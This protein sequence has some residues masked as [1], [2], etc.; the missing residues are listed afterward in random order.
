L[1]GGDW[2]KF[3]DVILAVAAFSVIY[4][5]VVAVLLMVLI[6]PMGSYLAM[7]TAGIV[8]ILIAGLL[9]GF[10]FAGQIQEESRMKAAGKIAVLLAFVELFAV[11]IGFPTNSYYGAWTKETLQSMYQTGSW[12]TTDWFVYEGL[13]TFLNVALNVVLVLVLGFI[14]LYAGSMLRKPKKT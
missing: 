5:L 14:G 13:A 3:G 4:V 10:L 2:L 7:N 11:L 1:G 6:S 9:A 8:S 12:T